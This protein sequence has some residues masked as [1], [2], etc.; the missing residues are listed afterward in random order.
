MHFVLNIYGR[1]MVSRLFR[2]LRRGILPSTLVNTATYTKRSL[3][4]EGYPSIAD[5]PLHELDK[6]LLII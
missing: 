5:I 6:R 2:C 1:G 4:D 3:F